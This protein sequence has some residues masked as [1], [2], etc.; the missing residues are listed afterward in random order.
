MTIS[1]ATKKRAYQITAAIGVLVV[2][3]ATAGLM[4]RPSPA[5]AEALIAAAAADG[6]Y[7][8]TVTSIADGFSL[9]CRTKDVTPS[10]ST[11]ASPS[12][13]PTASASST[14][15]SSSSPTV[16][17]SP[18]PSSTTRTS[19][20]TTTPSSPSGPCQPSPGSCGYPDAISTGP[21][22]TLTTLNGNQTFSSPNTQVA[23]TRINGC[24]E[25]RASNIT[26]KNVYFNGAGCFYAVRNFSSGLV[27]EDSFITCGETNGTGVTATGYTVRRSEITGCE[28]GF[29]VGGSVVLEDNWIHPAVTSGGAHTDGIQMN[30]G[31]ANITVRHN[32]IIVPAPGATSA[33]IMWDEG[34]PQNSN[35]L[36]TNN[37]LAGGTYTL[38]CPRQ[39]PVTNVVITNN[40]FGNFEYGH[41][42]GCYGN[43]ITT[44]S[45]NV[46][47]ATGAVYTE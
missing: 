43:H 14:A 5:S 9:V 47:D 44:W 1:Q 26:F 18:S 41:S 11:S 15:S 20:P 35:V 12:G 4:A 17:P 46:D 39:G 34:N 38:Y 27:I 16:S 3:A 6:Q 33:I 25:V 42:N 2:M 32:T 37:L 40:R 21:T 10:P 29:N 36:I 31:A 45:G 7:D 23:N 13:T 19:S 24:V 30:Q 22:S 8:C 28:N